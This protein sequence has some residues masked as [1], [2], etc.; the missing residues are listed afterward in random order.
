MQ[1]NLMLAALYTWTWASGQSGCQVLLGSLQCQYMGGAWLWPK[2]VVHR[3]GESSVQG[4]E[5]GG[6]IEDGSCNF[7]KRHT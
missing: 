6:I 4:L 7:T 3:A 2:K 5:R 1:P